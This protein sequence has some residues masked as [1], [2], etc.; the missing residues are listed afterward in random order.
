M[1]K[2]NFIFLLTVLAVVALDQATK[3]FIDGAMTLHASIP[4]IPGFFSITY[5]RNPGAAFGFL[6]GAPAVFRSFFFLAVTIAAVV[7]ILYYLHK[8][9]GR[10][11]L[12]TVSL[13]LILAGALGNMVDRLR[14]GE[15]ID[16]LD[17]YIGTAHWP[18]FNVADSAICVG[19]AVLFLALIRQDK[20][21]KTV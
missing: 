6:A 15:V 21:D 11:Q 10:G 20:E 4:V 1:K 5:I 3:F 17:V 2:T 14:L 13:S 9:P 7:L 8:T 18:A 19:A 16:F 12:L